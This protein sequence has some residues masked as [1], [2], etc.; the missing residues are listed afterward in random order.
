MTFKQFIAKLFKIKTKIE[1][2]PETMG[3]PIPPGTTLHN[4]SFFIE[5]LG[6]KHW[7]IIKL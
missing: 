3:Y 6:N 5:N 4:N 7:W 2:K 1:Y